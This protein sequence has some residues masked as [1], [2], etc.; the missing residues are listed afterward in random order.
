M[1][2]GRALSGNELDRVCGGQGATQADIDCV[3]AARG[4]GDL[5]S[6][7][8]GNGQNLRASVPTSGP[9]GARV[10]AA[11]RLC[12]ASPLAVGW[13]EALRRAGA[14]ERPLVAIVLNGAQ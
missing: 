2:A 6:W 14:P 12:A 4:V 7:S 9:E 10:A 11:E 8:G 13:A 3:R 1:S 5:I